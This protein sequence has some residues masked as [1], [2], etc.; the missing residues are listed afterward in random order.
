MQP[1]TMKQL[2][3]NCLAIYGFYCLVTDYVEKNYGIEIVVHNK[4][5]PID[6]EVIEPAKKK[7]WAVTFSR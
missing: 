7:K 5:D 1:L 2:V 4:K 6:P 3:I